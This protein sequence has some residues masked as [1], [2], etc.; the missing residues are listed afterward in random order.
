M[1]QDLSLREDVER[2][3]GWEPVV[4][5]AEIG[6][7]VRDGVVTLMGTVDSYVAKRAAERAAARVRD[8]RAI[9][10]QLEVKPVASAERSDADI[11][12]AGANVLAWNSLVP[13]ERVKVEVSHGHITLEGTVDWRFQRT[14]AEDAVVNLAGVTGLTN[15]IT[16]SPAVPS[17]ELK[18]E[19]EAALQRDAGTV[20]CRIIVEVARDRVTLWGSAASSG[21]REN[22]ERITWSVNGVHEVSN[23]ITAEATVAQTAAT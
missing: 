19:I 21:E 14:A 2:E 4:R 18:R 11:A 8:V 6:V 22:L 1:S 13:S 5:S 9:S 23:H 10:S 12:W 17:D 7:G 20:A 15:L 16:V 3:L